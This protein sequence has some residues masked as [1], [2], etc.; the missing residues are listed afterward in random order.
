MRIKATILA[1]AALLL[2]SCETMQCGTDSG[3]KDGGGCSAH[4][5]F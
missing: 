1:F 4:Q 3:P 5:K 2:A